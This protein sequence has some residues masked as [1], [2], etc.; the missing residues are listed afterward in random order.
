MVGAD[1]PIEYDALAKVHSVVDGDT[2]HG[3]R[4]PDPKVT[5]GPETYRLAGVDTHELDGPHDGRA[6]RE[7]L[8][9]KA[10][11]RMGIEAWDDDEWPFYAV[12]TADDAEGSFGR[13]LCDLVRRSDGAV[14]SDDLLAEFDDI[15]R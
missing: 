13:P 2:W 10:W 3:E 5:V 8:F 15:N 7:R 6:R 12:F 1:S 9:T 4:Q 14:L 11:V